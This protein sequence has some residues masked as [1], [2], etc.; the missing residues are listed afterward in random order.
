MAENFGHSGTNERSGQSGFHWGTGSAL[1]TAAI[2]KSKLGDIYMDYKSKMAIGFDGI[3][4][5]N[6]TWGDTIKL[7]TAKLKGIKEVKIRTNPNEKITKPIWIDNKS[8]GYILE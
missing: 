8:S 1:T 3:T 4:I 2:F 7:M 6:S 5:T